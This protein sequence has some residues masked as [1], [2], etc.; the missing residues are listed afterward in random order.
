MGGGKHPSRRGG[1]A[2]ADINPVAPGTATVTTVAG[3]YQY[4]Y[5]IQV[6]TNE[7]VVN[8]S[9]FTFFDVQGLISGSELAPAGW[10]VAQ[11][12]TGPTALGT[13]TQSLPLVDSASIENVT[14]T[15]DGTTPIVGVSNLGNFSFDSIYSQGTTSEGFTA[16]AEVTGTT[17]N[18]SNA[19]NYFGPTVPSVSPAPEPSE[20]ASFAIGGLGLLGLMLRARKTRAVQL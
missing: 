14:F 20:I 1:V 13:Y 15:Y 3:G 12:L 4:T 9:F 7:T 17:T 18:N 8:G 2:N 16:V 19:T 10:T 11:N 5:P 6:A